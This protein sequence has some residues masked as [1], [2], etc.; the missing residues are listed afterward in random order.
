MFLSYKTK[1]SDGT[2]TDFVGK[3][4]SGYFKHELFG[5]GNFHSVAQYA[6]DAL[7]RNLIDVP[8][9]DGYAN[10]ANTLAL[11]NKYPPKIHTIR[12]RV[13]RWRVGLNVQ[14]VINNRTPNVYQFAPST[15]FVSI[16]LIRMELTKPVILEAEFFDSVYIDIDGGSDLSNSQIKKLILNDGLTWRTFAEWFF[17]TAKH[18]PNCI[19]PGTWSGG[20]IHWTDHLY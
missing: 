1:F 17:G 2:P 8:T 10:E 6:D 16:Q 19:L 14:P 4:L 7:S 15:P 18:D 13:D 20:V 3:I 5:D 12:S 9:N 11:E